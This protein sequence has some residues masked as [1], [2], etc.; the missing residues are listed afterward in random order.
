MSVVRLTRSSERHPGSLRSPARIVDTRC[1]ETRAAAPAAR[2]AAMNAVRDDSPS[3]PPFRLR[4]EPLTPEAERLPGFEWPSDDVGQRHRLGG[5]PE[6]LQGD[7]T[8]IWRE[9]GE[10]MTFYGQ[11]DSINDD[12]V[13]GDV[14]SSTSSSASTT[15]RRRP[16]SSRCDGGTSGHAVALPQHIRRAFPI[17]R[18]YPTPIQERRSEHVTDPPSGRCDTL[19]R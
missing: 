17:D 9:C 11:L 1:Y 5:E 10:K 13:S 18:R 8:P 15:S 7:A 12:I 16:S 2:F 3:I 6:W 14:A 4:P 19:P